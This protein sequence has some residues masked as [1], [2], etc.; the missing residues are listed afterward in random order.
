MKIFKVLFYSMAIL[1]VLQ[2]CN[3]DEDN[4]TDPPNNAPVENENENN[5]NNNNA[6]DDTSDD[7]Q[8]QDVQDDQS[9]QDDPLFNF[10]SFDLDIDYQDNKEIDVDY[11]NENDGMEAE[12]KDTVNDERLSGDEAFEKLRPIF[13]ELTFDQN[14]ENEAVIS[15][16]LTAFDLNNDFTK[17]ELE[18]KFTDGTE[19]EYNQ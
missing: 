17:L 3:N 5:N 7:N 2:G 10:T 13:E 6:S 12:Y 1:L 19:K 16:V 14:T 8:N 4:V 15:E 9:G 11:E 18:I